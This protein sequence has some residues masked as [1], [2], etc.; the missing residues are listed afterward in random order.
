MQL[1]G[2]LPVAPFVS[3][4]NLR[5]SI[6]FRNL[7]LELDKTQI[8]DKIFYELELETT[9]GRRSEDQTALKDWFAAHN[10]RY[11]PSRVSKLQRALAM[12]S[13]LPHGS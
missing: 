7:H 9:P 11:T 3:F 12:H 8:L 4:Q 13:E 10:W 5:R 6:T 2:N 1:F